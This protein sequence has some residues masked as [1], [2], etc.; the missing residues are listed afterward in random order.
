MPNPDA[1][2]RDRLADAAIADDTEHRAVHVDAQEV[3]DVEPGPAALAEVGL[4]VGRPPR[5]RE[6]QEEGEIGGGLVEHPRRVAD[7]DPELGSGGEVD[8]VVAHGHVGDDL[9]PRRARPQDVGVDAIGE[10][11][12][13]R[14][15]VGDRGPQVG[16][17]P[18]LVAVALHDLVSGGDERI[19]PPLRQLA[20]DQDAGHGEGA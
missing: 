2:S 7:R 4:G 12:D 1:A 10:D 13:H 19:E 16:G 20:G 3:A 18:G 5:R 9:Q 15:H 6:Q 11:A 14:V 17:G 8:V